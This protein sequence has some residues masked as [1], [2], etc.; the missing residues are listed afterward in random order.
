MIVLHTNVY[1]RI[2][3]DYPEFFTEVTGGIQADDVILF[4]S[5]AKISTR[6]NIIEEPA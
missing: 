5:I 6:T 2:V 4:G 3:K 1:R